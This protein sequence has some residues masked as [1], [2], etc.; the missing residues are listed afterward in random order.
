MALSESAFRILAV[1]PTGSAHN[2]TIPVLDA[3]TMSI[4]R[5]LDEMLIDPNFTSNGAAHFSDTNDLWLTNSSPFHPQLSI[6]VVDP[7]TGQ[8]LRFISGADRGQIFE[9]DPL[10]KNVF[11]G[12]QE[13]Q[14]LYTVPDRADTISAQL[15]VEASP[16]EISFDAILDNYQ[17]LSKNGRLYLVS[18]DIPSVT[19]NRAQFLNR[20]PSFG[21][22][23][24]SGL[25]SDPDRRRIFVGRQPGLPPLAFETERYQQIGELPFPADAMAIDASRNLLYVAGL[26][27]GATLGRTI[28][29]IDGD[30]LVVLRDLVVL[31]DLPGPSG[32]APA[33]VEMVVDTVGQGLWVLFPL[34]AT[35]PPILRAYSITSGQAIF[36]D[37]ILQ[38]EVVSNLN[39][40]SK[41]NRILVTSE[42]PG[43]DAQTFPFSLTSGIGSPF[44]SGLSSRLD[45]APD[46][47]SEL[48]YY[49]G[50]DEI[51]QGYRLVAL[52][53][54]TDQIVGNF[55]LPFLSGAENAQIAFNPSTN[56]FAISS[57][58][59]SFVH[60]FHNPLPTTIRP[61]PGPPPLPKNSGKI[62]PPAVMGQIGQ[63][64]HGIE[65]T[66]FYDHPLVRG[67]VIERRRAPSPSFV[68]NEEWIRLTPLPLTPDQLSFTDVTAREGVP[69]LYRV[70]V[71]LEGSFAVDPLLLGQVLWGMGSNGWLASIP[72]LVV[73]LRPDDGLNLPITISTETPTQETVRLQVIQADP[74]VFAEAF[75][76]P[77]TV[78]RP[79][80][81]TLNIVLR[82]G[83]PRGTYPL[84]VEVSEAGS[85]SQTL[86][87]LVRIVD[88]LQG[89]RTQHILR[90]PARIRLSSDSDL[91][92]GRI[93]L[94]GQLGSQRAEVIPTGMD[95]TARR[96]DGMIVNADRVIVATGE[97]T[98]EFDVPL[99]NPQGGIWALRATW[100]SSLDNVGG[101][102]PLLRI[103]LFAGGN[104]GGGPGPELGR[105][106]MAGAE[107]PAGSMSQ[108]IDLVLDD[109]FDTFVDNRFDEATQAKLNSATETLV[110]ESIENAATET[111][112]LVLLYLVGKAETVGAT[113]VKM[114]MGEGG[115]L[116]P[117]EI[118][119]SFLAAA[120]P[121][122]VLDC[123][124][125]D[126][127]K[128]R[129]S[130]LMDGAFIFSSAADFGGVGFEPSRLT[131]F[132]NEYLQSIGD[133]LGFG[134]AF[135]DIED[136]FLIPTSGLTAP[137]SPTQLNADMAPFV[138][139]AVGSHF[140]PSRDFLDDRLPP[141]FIDISP[142]E[143]STVGQTIF[144][145]VE[146]EDPPFDFDASVR[147]QINHP[148]SP[149]EMV[150]LVKDA[151][152][153]IHCGSFTVLD[154]GLTLLTYRAEDS[155]G[156]SS[157]AQSSVSV[158][159]PSQTPTST[160]TE[161]GTVTWTPTDADTPTATSTST[162]THTPSHT[163]TII[164]EPTKSSTPTPTITNTPEGATH[165]FTITP[166]QT[167]TPT[168]TTDGPTPTATLTE[169]PSNTPDGA[170]ETFTSTPTITQT[171]TP[172]ITPTGSPPTP[173]PCI[174]NNAD[175]N[176]DG[177]INAKDII[178][179][180]YQLLGGDP[181]F[182]IGADM[183]CDGELNS[184][185]VFLF[186]L[187]SGTQ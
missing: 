184:L 23:P 130:D 4:V 49:L 173:T 93:A 50:F 109:I 37:I 16:V 46:I 65:L 181:H 99:G 12:S 63:T 55:I 28:W 68:P 81:S 114:M 31:P 5:L 158:P 42:A 7:Q 157:F 180:Y 3:A 9:I 6:A 56:R 11:V 25:L 34:T 177:T 137:Q 91:E 71:L 133:G 57:A 101:N 79:G 139:L 58:P 129:L 138:E 119:S 86:V 66:Y 95:V 73:S 15:D 149:L 165:T 185:D 108:D 175:L 171:V 155:E 92:Q 27:I 94:R 125:A 124:Y 183:N 146:I 32:P 156:N 152:A 60:L 166:T 76:F 182:G 161:T 44:A 127:F 102:S 120:T 14:S 69:Y 24:I 51:M 82:G 38:G 164:V 8:P 75:A 33:P 52:D 140:T 176:N 97:F 41:R 186:Q 179:L 142:S 153:N 43:V 167:G 106:V 145:D 64:S 115:E 100:P 144:V 110:M 62:S 84:V 85:A 141:F 118:A 39:L 148:S 136:I 29:E 74:T 134:E 80:V 150:D 113:D 10:S 147:L 154:P 116:T 26:P 143:M 90:H 61:Q 13:L 35:A 96:G 21:D 59:D 45:A 122:V 132:S 163:N 20:I 178:E 70:Q 18:D 36:G 83:I 123:P 187:L 117:E 47:D 98:A 111:S 22:N 170:T 172:T 168:N 174:E 87:L 103:P 126:R 30:S 128:S 2:G 107:P 89:V 151:S 78:P 77:G 1:A 112:G 54:I 19:D 72:D 159:L 131:T 88:D 67:Y 160:P 104:K 162:P 105:I 53:L 40:D 121:L 169:T 48:L 135:D 17:V